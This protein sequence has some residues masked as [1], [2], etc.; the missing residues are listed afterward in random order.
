MR[1]PLVSIVVALSLLSYSVANADIIFF[2]DGNIRGDVISEEINLNSGVLEDMT[3]KRKTLLGLR[4]DNEKNIQVKYKDGQN[5]I[6][7]NYDLS[8]LFKNQETMKGS[9]LERYLVT[10]NRI[11]DE[12]IINKYQLVRQIDNYCKRIGLNPGFVMDSVLYST[13]Y[14][15]N[16]NALKRNIICAVRSLELAEDFTDSDKLYLR[17]IHNKEELESLEAEFKK[18]GYDTIILNP[19]SG[20]SELTPF[21]V[22]EDIAEFSVILFHERWHENSGRKYSP[23]IEESIA[24]VMGYICAE[25]FLAEVYGIDSAEV[26]DVR[27]L[28][29]KFSKQ[30]AAVLECY[31]QLS[32]LYNMDI[33]DEEK[34]K[35]KEEI[36]SNIRK[37]TDYTFNNA[38]LS[39]YIT[40]SKYYNLVNEI[41]KNSENLADTVTLLKRT[42][43]FVTEKKSVEYLKSLVHR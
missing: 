43:S 36:T 34:L 27:H 21:S 26:E 11:P 31:T 20:G 2:K 16:E 35:I 33:C 12:E 13:F 10:N 1:K 40:Y 18:N 3:L 41:V 5:K 38:S 15:Y 37:T 24:S 22:E 19:I 32:D 7:R 28:K 8:I 6:Y 23:R 9:N 30:S 25:K 14:F 39:V 42:N 17:P 4:I 29:N